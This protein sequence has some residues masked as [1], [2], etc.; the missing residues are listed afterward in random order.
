MNFITINFTAYYLF[1]HAIFYK[2]EHFSE[3]K[4]VRL[5]YIPN[6]KIFLEVG[7]EDVLPDNLQNIGFGNLR[8]AIVPYR[9]YN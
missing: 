4:E 2:E 9:S 8:K 6:T 5:V 3:E 7:L 1:C